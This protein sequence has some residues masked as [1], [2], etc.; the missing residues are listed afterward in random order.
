MSNEVI[1]QNLTEAFEVLKDSWDYKKDAIINCIVETERYDGALS[2]D[3]WLYVLKSHM[4]IETQEDANTLVKDVLERFFK[5]NE[6]HDFS[7][8]ENRCRAFL[9]HVVPHL[10]NNDEL[11][12]CIFKYTYNAAYEYNPEWDNLLNQNIAICIGCMILEGN[13]HTM[14]VL[15]ESLSQNALLCEI[16]MGWLLLKANKYIEY[17]CRNEDE[18]GKKYTVSDEVKNALL[19]SLD[20]IKDKSER[21]E[22]TIAFLSY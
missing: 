17:I 16:S 1:I 10:I 3:M 14:E 15:I 22:C 4:P 7:S 11:I 6:A 21:A 12:R 18:F 2:M 13:K 9:N 5:K 19:R 8:G 20:Y